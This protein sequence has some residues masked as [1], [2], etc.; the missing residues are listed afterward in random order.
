MGNTIRIY[1]SKQS[2]ALDARFS[3]SPEKLRAIYETALDLYA[4][5]PDVGDMVDDLASVPGLPWNGGTATEFSSS[6]WAGGRDVL[7]KHAYKEAFELALKHAVP[8]P[9][10]TLWVTNAGDDFELHV[11]DGFDR[12]TVFMVV[13]PGEGV[14]NSSWR[15]DNM[16]WVVTSVDARQPDEGREI[17]EL[18]P[19]E[20]V[21]I[22]ISGKHG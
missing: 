7:L 10:E 20:V 11:V 1:R 16:A 18:A 14:M 13:P 2:E 17:L 12:V 19:G 5:Y 15:A 9:V 3:G 6:T 8:V 4:R 22:E 21:K